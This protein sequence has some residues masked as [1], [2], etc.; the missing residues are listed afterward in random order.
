MQRIVICDP[1]DASREP[2][3]SLLLGVDF[4]FLDSECKRYEAFCDI[5]VE[6]PPELAVIHLDA[7][8]AK[9]LQLVLQLTHE[10]PQM[11]LLVVSKDNQAILQALQ[12]GAKHFLTEPVVLEDMLR[13]LRKVQ[14]DQSHSRPTKGGTGGTPTGPRLAQTSQVI[15]VLG[16]RGGVGCTS[17]AVNLGCSLAA[18]PHNSA[19]LIDLDLAL[20]DA[21]VALDLLPSHTLADLMLNIDKLDL[22]FLRRSLAPHPGTNLALLAHPFHLSEVGV[23]QGQHVERILN[24]LRMSFTHLIIDLSKG[25]TPVDVTALEMADV[26]LLVAQADLT[27]L[28]NVVRIMMSFGEQDGLAEK[29]RVVMNRVG[30]EHCDNQIS[31]KKAEATIGK[32]IY[33]QVP[34]DARA[35]LG[36]RVAGEPLIKHAPRSKAHQ[37]IAALAAALGQSPAT[38]NGHAGPRATAVVARR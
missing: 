24:L 17:L 11:P 35:V 18:D 14:A 16:S 37:S 38:V 3:R 19:V 4:V 36:A 27:S 29:V 20:G 2:L 23:V 8:K 5:V 22:N 32:P 26:V 21:D 9:A 25:L 34:N 33:W 13:A 30:A 6:A 7:D 10:F 15:A 1:S 12:S 28:R 31:L